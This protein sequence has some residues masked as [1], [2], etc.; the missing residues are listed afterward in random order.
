MGVLLTSVF[1]YDRLI[2]LHTTARSCL[3]EANDLFSV[4]Q[5]PPGISGV[6]MNSLL[7]SFQSEPFTS[8]KAS[9]CDHDKPESILAFRKCS[10]TAHFCIRVCV[11]K[12][13]L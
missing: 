12:V 5:Y 4:L 6:I 9:L 1:P 13:A 8:Q 7:P 11:L 2:C 10:C 3:S